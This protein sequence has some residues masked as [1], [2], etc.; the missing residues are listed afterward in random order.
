MEIVSPHQEAGPCALCQEGA[1][2]HH[3]CGWCGATFPRMEGLVAHLEDA[4]AGCFDKMYA[5]LMAHRYDS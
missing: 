4:D 3:H 5:V 1:S 2:K